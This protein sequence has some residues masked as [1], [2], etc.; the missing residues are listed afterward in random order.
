MF[1]NIGFRIGISKTNL[2]YKTIV[3]SNTNQ[4]ITDYSNIELHPNFTKEVINATF[5]GN[6]EIE[7]T[8]KL[9]YY[10][11]PLEIYKPLT[12]WKSKFGID[13]ILGITPQVIDKNTLILSDTNSKSYEIGKVTNV[14]NVNIGFH[15]GFG[16]NYKLTKSIQLD[17]NPIFK[18]QSIPYKDHHSF[19]PFYIAIQSG[20]SYKF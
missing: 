4:F 17:L 10:E 12:K 3:P 6:N 14:R 5:T 18:Y 19:N 15:A 13:L 16:F 20:F 8:Q 1:E 2:S 9:S 7:L 11:I